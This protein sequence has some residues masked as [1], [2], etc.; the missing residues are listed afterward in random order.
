MLVETL[1]AEKVLNS[2]GDLSVRLY[3][4]RPILVLSYYLRLGRLS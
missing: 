4:S 2:R 1:A 3:L